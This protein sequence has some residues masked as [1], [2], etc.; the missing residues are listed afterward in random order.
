[1]SALDAARWLAE[2]WPPAHTVGP[3]GLP[4]CIETTRHVVDAF[5]AAG[6]ADA[7]ALP[8]ALHAFNRQASA[9]ILGGNSGDP[10]E[11]ALHV[12][13]SPEAVRDRKARGWAGHL[14]VD[15][16][17]FILDLVLPGVFVSTGAHGFEHVGPFCGEKGNELIEVAGSWMAMGTDGVCL[18]YVPRP[19]LA[20]WKN[21]DAWRAAPDRNVV[22]V[23]SAQIA[24]RLA[25]PAA[26]AA[27][28]LPSGP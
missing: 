13:V 11:G 3:T 12:E 8:C 15:H 7:R 26:G 5:H 14:V 4:V 24:E 1:M 23:L 10:E 20:S 18:R 19:R 9:F 2:L 28:P 21:T 16:P 25:E 22:R 27:E 6:V 17:E